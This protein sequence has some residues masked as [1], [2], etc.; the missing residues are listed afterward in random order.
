MTRGPALPRNSLI[1]SELRGFKLKGF[2]I[3][4]DVFHQVAG[5]FQGEMFRI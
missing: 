5:E 3:V 2:G 4:L 1:L